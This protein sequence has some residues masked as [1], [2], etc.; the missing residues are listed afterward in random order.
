[1][2]YKEGENISGGG[3]SPPPE[4]HNRILGMEYKG[5]GSPFLSNNYFKNLGTRLQYNLDN[6]L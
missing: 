3:K 1:M 6:G 2:W 4:K 5:G